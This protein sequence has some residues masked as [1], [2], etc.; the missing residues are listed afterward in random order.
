MSQANSNTE[1]MMQRPQGKSVM[2]AS[3]SAPNA[4]EQAAL[5]QL[6]V[7]KL[8]DLAECLFALNN[9]RFGPIAGAYLVV[10]TKPD[11]QWCV[12]QLNA[13]RAKPIILFEDQVY[14]SPELA[15]A[16]AQRMKQQRGESAPCRS[17]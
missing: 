5:A 8:N 9:R 7:D 4:L 3:A 17:T 15:Q 12:G 2:G 1:T 16:A 11:E 14:H 6:D 13:D 10:C